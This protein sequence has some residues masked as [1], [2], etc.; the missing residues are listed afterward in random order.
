MLK[1]ILTAAAVL[2]LAAGAAG[3]C[4]LNNMKTTQ[5]PVPAVTAQAPIQTP[6]PVAQVTATPSTQDVAQATIAKPATETKT[7]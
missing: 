7:N 3:A 1:V 4:E 5:S 6:A 2:G